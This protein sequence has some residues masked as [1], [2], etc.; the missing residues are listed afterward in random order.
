M[1]QIAVSEQGG[2][3]TG[4]V[5]SAPMGGDDRLQHRRHAASVVA[6]SAIV[7]GLLM[8]AV[9][10]ADIRVAAALG[11]GGLLPAATVDLREQRLPDRL[12][13]MGGLLLVI[14]LTLDMVGGGSLPAASML[15]GLITAGSPLLLIHVVSPVAL[16]FGDV[17]TAVVLG[18][19]L[20]VVDWRL[21]LV[22]LVLAA[23]GAAVVGLIL[24]IEAIAFG[25]ALVMAAAAALALHDNVLEV[26]AP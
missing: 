19:S 21:S 22:M 5:A 16:G 9:L 26:L 25:P 23:G 18:A 14:A 20:G 7:T 6:L 11:V 3:R 24:R 13:A 1:E 4:S 15:A 12:V 2:R 17:K 10:D 8:Y